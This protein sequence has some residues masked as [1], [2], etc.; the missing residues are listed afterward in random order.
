MRIQVFIENVNLAPSSHK[1]KLQTECLSVEQCSVVVKCFTCKPKIEQQVWVQTCHPRQERSQNLH[2]C[3]CLHFAKHNFIS[4]YPPPT[5]NKKEK[6]KPFLNNICFI[7]LRR[8]QLTIGWS[9]DIGLRVNLTWTFV[10]VQLKYVGTDAQMHRYSGRRTPCP[11]LCPVLWCLYGFVAYHVL[12]F[13][14]NLY[15]EQA[16]KKYLKNVRY[17]SDK[18]KCVNHCKGVYLHYV[19]TE[20]KTSAGGQSNILVYKSHIFKADRTKL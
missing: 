8:N 5:P 17:K 14:K 16:C 12:Q 1:V 3:K 4:P 20:R 9:L 7:Y 19:R 18:S 2:F 11:P 6:E 10:T 13:S 15:A